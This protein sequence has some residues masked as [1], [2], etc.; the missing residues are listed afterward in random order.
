MPI[1][2][3]LSV[4]T[5]S[6]TLRSLALKLTYA[7]SN[8]FAILWHNI[9]TILHMLGVPKASTMVGTSLAKVSETK[10]KISSLET[11]KKNFSQ[12]IVYAEDDARRFILHG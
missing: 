8:T 1:L 4:L 10:G 6:Y 7:N 5:Y 3:V 2:Q 9:P 12:K 11:G